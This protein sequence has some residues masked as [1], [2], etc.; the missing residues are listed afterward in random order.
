[1]YPQILVTKHKL[2][3][4]DIISALE[5]IEKFVKDMKFEEFQWDDKTISAVIR[6]FEVV[7][8]ATR[9]LPDRIIEKYTDVPWKRMAGMRNKL[10][11][12]YF[13]LDYK[14]VWDSIKVEIPK[15]LHKIKKVLDD[16]ESNAMNEKLNL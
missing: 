11:H 1:M 2:F 7:G 3:V 15:V 8:E 6:K 16:I 9:N 4:M 12:G 5:S 14:L 10:I 13:G